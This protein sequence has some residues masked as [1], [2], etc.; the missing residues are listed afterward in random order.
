M[1]VSRRLD[2]TTV[3]AMRRVC[4][5]ADVLVLHSIGTGDLAEPTSAS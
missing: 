4:I 1:D 5:D 2:D 3:D